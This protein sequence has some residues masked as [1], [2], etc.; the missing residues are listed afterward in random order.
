M[1]PWSPALN[2]LPKWF[3]TLPHWA[4]VQY[5]IPRQYS[6]LRGQGWRKTGATDLFCLLK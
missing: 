5:R 3:D 1:I 4:F 6:H 2:A